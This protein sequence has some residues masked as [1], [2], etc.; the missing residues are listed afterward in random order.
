MYDSSEVVFMNDDDASQSVND[1]EL[2]RGK[3]KSRESHGSYSSLEET[4]KRFKITNTPGE[5]RY[6]LYF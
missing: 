2:F 1:D 3:R 6:D 5:L 4:I